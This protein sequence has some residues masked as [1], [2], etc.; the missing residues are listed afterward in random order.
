MPVA[1]HALWPDAAFLDGLEQG[2]ARLTLM[3]AVAEAAMSERVPEFD[4]TGFH[5]GAADMAYVSNS[6][7]VTNLKGATIEKG[8]FL[9]VWKLRKDKWLIVFDMF[10]PAPPEQK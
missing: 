4:E 6:Y 2:A 5:V 8:T 10:V 1:G 7:T 3:P 9:Q